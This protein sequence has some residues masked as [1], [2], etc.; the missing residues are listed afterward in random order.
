LKV[1]LKKSKKG[2]TFAVE[3]HLMYVQI[4]LGHL[5]RWNPADDH[6]RSCSLVVLDMMVFAWVIGS[7]GVAFSLKKLKQTMCSMALKPLESHVVGFG[8]LGG[9]GAHRESMRSVVV[10]CDGSGF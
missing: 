1:F 9:H 7:I 5:L 8:C 6:R 4:H 2:H 10:S 3:C